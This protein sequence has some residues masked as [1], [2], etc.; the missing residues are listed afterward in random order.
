MMDW[1]A[2]LWLVLMIVFILIEVSTV[3]MVSVWFASGA[4]TALIASLCNAP[5]W[6]QIVLFVVVSAALLLALRPLA[7]KYFTP[8]LTKTN[9]DA[10]V[11][12]EGLVTQRID[13]L[14]AS[15]SVKLGGV[16]WS[17]RSTSGAPLEEGTRIRVDR[18]EGVK[19]FVTAA[20]VPVQ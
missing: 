10:V 12:T 4:L 13:N 11:G 20:E 2:I 3:S 15:G 16:E 19:V 1:F 17:A 8:R 9:V 5:L 14:S 6:L 7:R 18:V